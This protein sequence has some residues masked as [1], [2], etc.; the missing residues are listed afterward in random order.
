MKP[1]SNI[2]SKA[3][4]STI[5]ILV[6]LCLGAFLFGR[7]LCGVGNWVISTNYSWLA[8]AFCNPTLWL[9]GLDEMMWEWP[10]FGRT[11]VSEIGLIFLCILSGIVHVVAIVASIGGL[12]ELWN[13][14]RKKK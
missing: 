1:Y 5:V 9:L 8:I 3:V 4:Y 7:I 10:H 6:G 12:C 2:N 13:H 11:D 14:I